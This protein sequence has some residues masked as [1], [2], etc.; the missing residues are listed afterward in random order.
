M[1]LTDLQLLAQQYFI[2]DTGLGLAN[3]VR[4]IQLAEGHSDCFSTD[5]THC[6]EIRCRW[7][8]EC[9]PCGTDTENKAAG[10]AATSNRSA[11]GFDHD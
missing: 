9:L 7:R 11:T 6:D 4:K 2:A 5:K 3:L 10:D 8:I 1:N